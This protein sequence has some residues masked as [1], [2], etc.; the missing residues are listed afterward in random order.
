MAEFIAGFNRLL[1]IHSDNLLNG[2]LCTIC[3]TSGMKPSKHPGRFPADP[4]DYQQG[5]EGAGLRA[6]EADFIGA[7]FGGGKNEG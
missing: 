2:S 7:G 6:A 1:I 4:E 5:D 3:K